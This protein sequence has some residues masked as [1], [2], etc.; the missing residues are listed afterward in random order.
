MH[1]R[2]G[3]IVAALVYT[4]V[5]TSQDKN[6]PT[7]AHRLVIENPEVIKLEVTPVTQRRRTGV[8]EKR[9]GPYKP[10]SNIAFDLLGTNTSTLPLMVYGWDTYSQNRPQLSKDGFDVPYRRGL[11]DVLKSKYKELGTEVIHLV[12]TRLE[13]GKPSVIEKISLNAWYETLSPGT[14]ELSLKHRFMQSGKW[15]NA[16]P[17]TFQIDDVSEKS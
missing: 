12:T 5:S 9:S 6:G 10:G 14:Y 7:Q 8:Y 3:L 2:T 4:L 15:V 17:V 13:P 1:L 16:K 11:E